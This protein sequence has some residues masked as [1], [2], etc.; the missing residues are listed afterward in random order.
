MISGF[1]LVLIT[2]LNARELSNFPFT[3]NFSVVPS[4]VIAA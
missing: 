3:Y 4:Y 1:E 2:P